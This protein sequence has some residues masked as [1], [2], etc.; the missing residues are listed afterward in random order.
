[1]FDVTRIVL[2]GTSYGDKLGSLR[3]EKNWPPLNWSKS[4]SHIQKAHPIFT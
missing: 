3:P 2:N 1:M 4:H